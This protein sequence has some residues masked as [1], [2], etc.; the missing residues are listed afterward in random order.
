MDDLDIAISS[1]IGAAWA[2]NLAFSRPISSMPGAVE[3]SQTGRVLVHMSAVMTSGTSFIATFRKYI[4]RLVSSSWTYR[5]RPAQNEWPLTFQ[6]E[7]KACKDEFSRC[8]F[9]RVLK[10]DPGW[11]NNL[12]TQDCGGPSITFFQRLPVSFEC[13]FLYMFPSTRWDVPS[14][15][16]VFSQYFCWPRSFDARFKPYCYFF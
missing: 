10:L 13:L 3:P 6:Q 2:V 14:F 15:L 1:T 4:R 8:R 7:A 9:I 16:A 11:P 12:V 5:A